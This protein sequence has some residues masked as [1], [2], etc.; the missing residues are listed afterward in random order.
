VQ[1]V[2]GPGGGYRLKRALDSIFVAQI[3]DAVNESVDAT[4]C[5]G[6]GNCHQGEVCLTHHLWEDLSQQIHIFLNQISLADLVAKRQRLVGTY[7]VPHHLVHDSLERPLQFAD[8]S[9]NE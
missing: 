9:V 3:I 8:L 7:S 2:R 6:K 4:S 1:S 5:G